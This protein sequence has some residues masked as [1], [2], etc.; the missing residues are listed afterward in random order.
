VFDNFKC[1][2]IFSAI[3][4]KAGD[5]ALIGKIPPWAAQLK[6]DRTV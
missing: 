5:P 2:E 6:A 4:D 3:C 1:R